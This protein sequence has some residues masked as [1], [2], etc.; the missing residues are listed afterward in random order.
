M[1]SF[2]SSIGTHPSRVHQ[3]QELEASDSAG[4]GGEGGELDAGGPRRTG[5]GQ[6]R[7]GRLSQ[8][9][10]VPRDRRV[11]VCRGIAG[12]SYAEGS[13]G[14]RLSVCATGVLQQI[15]RLGLIWFSFLLSLFSLLIA[16]LVDALV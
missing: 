14:M 7:R 8:S 13:P 2:N 3:H 16:S 4:P 6:T 5:A 12:Y 10:L 15:L 9:A 11:C 1:V